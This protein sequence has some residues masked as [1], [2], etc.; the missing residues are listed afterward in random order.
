MGQANCVA[1]F[2]TS[3]VLIQYRQVHANKNQY[4]C[5]ILYSAVFY[6]CLSVYLDLSF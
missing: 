2:F 1:H 3:L 5:F 4:V 6:F